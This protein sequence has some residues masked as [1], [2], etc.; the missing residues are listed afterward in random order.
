[1]VLSIEE[2]VFLVEYIFQAGNRYTDLLQEQFGEKF[3]EPPVPHCSA[4]HRLTEKF[5]ETG[6][7][8]DTKQSGRPS[9]HKRH[10]TSRSAESVCE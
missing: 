3:P 1:M 2:R 7:V 5:N 10:L 9:K 8:L 4:V 6:S